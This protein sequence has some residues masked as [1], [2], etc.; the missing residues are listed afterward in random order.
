MNRASQIAVDLATC[1]CRLAAEEG[2]EFCFCGVLP[3][4]AVVADYV[5]MCEGTCGMAWVRM[6]SAYP[7]AAVGRPNEQ[8]GNCGVLLGVEFEI[9]MLRCFPSGDNDGEPPTMDEQ[10][11]AAVRQH[12]DMLLMQRAIMCC[13]SLGAKDYILGAYAPTGPM[14]YVYGGGWTL[15]VAI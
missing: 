14:G 6:T 5:G 8:V 11:A 3:G 15:M 1:L 2:T 4:D 9:G 7:A 12:D 13:P 10:L